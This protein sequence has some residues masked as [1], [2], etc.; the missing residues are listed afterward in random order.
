MEFLWIHYNI[1]LKKCL[2]YISVIWLIENACEPCLI[3]VWKRMFGNPLWHLFGRECLKMPSEICLEKNPCNASLEYLWMHSNIC[4]KK[5]FVIHLSYLIDREC[6]WTL[7]DIC[8]KKNVW[9]PLLAFA[10]KKMVGNHEK[11]YL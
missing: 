7:S 3:F 4:F 6:L 5:M 11:E 2:W 9:K 8:L 10:W 1:C